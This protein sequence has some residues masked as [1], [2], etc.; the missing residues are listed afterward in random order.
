[1]SRRK[2]L[3]I[4]CAAAILLLCLVTGLG[5]IAV[6][7]EEIS[8][9][10]D[11]EQLQLYIEYP[12]V[13]EQ[14]NIWRA[15]D[16]F[17]FFLPMDTKGQNVFFGNLRE[18]DSIRIGA[19]SYSF[20]DDFQEQIE[21]NTSYEMQ[22]CIAGNYLEKQQVV[23]MR[24]ANLPAVYIDTVSGSLDSVH[25]DKEIKEAASLTLVDE[26]GRCLY[27]EELEYIK[28][29]GN[30]TFLEV[31]KKSY[32]IKLADKS[33]L[34]G[35][36]EAKKW[37]LLANAKDASLIR[38]KL[39]FDYAG[40]YTDVPSIDGEYVDL[41]VNGDYIGT[42]F[43]CEKVEVLA[44]RLSITD[45]DKKNEAV[46]SKT[47]LESAP[48]YVSADGK[49]RALSGL[50]NPDD[51]T[52]GYLLEK[53][54]PDE[55]EVARAAFI[56]DCENY[57]C[58]VSP[59]NATV[60]QVEYICG[61]FNELEGA[62]N[63]PDGRNP[64]TGKHFSEYLDMD[65]WISKYLMEEAFSDPDV[66]EGSVYFYKD[67]DSADALIYSGPMWDYDR[68]MGAYA[69]GRYYLDDPLQMGYRAVYAR[70]L[71]GHE[72][73]MEAV[74]HKYRESFLPYV[75]LE[76]AKEVDFLQRKLRA[77]AAMNFTRWPEVI[78]YY[79]AWDANSE[80]ILDFLEARKDYLNDAWLGEE[81]YH[82]V[83]FLDYNGRLCDKYRVKHGEYLPAVPTIASHV[84]IF[85]GWVSTTNGNPL[86]IRLPILE[87][88]EYQSE[89]IDV[90][91]I[92]QNGVARAETN[93]DSIN[94]EGIE[95]LVEEIKRLRSEE[96]TPE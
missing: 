72:E 14:V 17:Y 32:Q 54:G 75:R 5:Q 31:E 77:S 92:L 3:L 51:I 46:N 44:G 10:E 38:N 85:N 45:L 91:L 60:E 40:Q 27:D 7:E 15:E 23:F 94:V 62:V 95:A 56:T 30:S 76:A 39:V 26:Q 13:T 35:M 74:K 78:G 64:D 55:Y 25:E 11:Y 29:R 87:D 73:V 68:T 79:E 53:I 16:C 43:L 67:S 47:Q 71:L 33:S 80:F 65:S 19:D 9:A 8:Y 63:Q 52:G 48:Q 1:M 22:L 37:L 4:L 49:I 34:L 21:W 89:W 82:T 20:G 59:E 50:N 93:I 41:Y 86:D 90:G 2:W 69:V 42:Y 81:Q 24:S 12:K 83:T 66:P 58:V 6:W 84:A 70:E 36:E 61:L 28:A 18:S 96:G 57:Y 88:A